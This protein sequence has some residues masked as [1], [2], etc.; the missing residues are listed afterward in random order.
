MADVYSEWL[1]SYGTLQQ[2]AVQLTYFSRKLQGSE[3]SGNLGFSD[4]SSG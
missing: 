2:E 4:M 3:I 1:F